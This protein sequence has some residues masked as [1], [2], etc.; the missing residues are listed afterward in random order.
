MAEGNLNKS[1]YIELKEFYDNNAGELYSFQ[2]FDEAGQTEYRVFTEKVKPLKVFEQN[3]IAYELV[4]I[5]FLSLKRKKSYSDI[6]KFIK[7][8]PVIY[9]YENLRGILRAVIEEDQDKKDML[10]N[11]VKDIIYNSNNEEM[12][13]LSIIAAQ[14]VK[15]ENLEEILEV[16][17]IHNKF[18]FYVINDYEHIDGSNEKIFKIAKSSKSYGKLFSLAALNMSNTYMEDWVIEKGCIDNYGITEITEYS[19]L[20]ADLLSY[21]NRTKFDYDKIEVFAKSFSIMISDYGISEIKDKIEVCQKLLEI[22]DDIGGGIYSLYAVVS[23]LYSVDGIIVDYYKEKQRIETLKN[24]EGYKNIIELCTDICSEKCWNDVIEEAIADIEIEPDVLVTCIE[25]TEYKLKKKE[26]ENLLKRDYLN[27]LLYKYALCV[28]NKAIRKSAF[29]LGVKNL[30]LNDMTTGAEELKI[31]ELTYDEISYICLYIII[32]YSQIKDFTDDISDCKELLLNS[33]QCPLIEIREECVNKLE[34]IKD[35]LNE[36]EVEFIYDCIERE[37]I[38]SIR[39]A[40]KCIA[41]ANDDDNNKKSIYVEPPER[42]QLHPKDTFLIDSEILGNDVFDRT[43]VESLI[44]ENNIVYV[45]ENPSED[46]EH[47]SVVSMNNGYIIGYIEKPVDDIL[48]NMI[49]SGRYIYG[50]IKNID[51]DLSEIKISIF[52]SYRDVEDGV[53]DVLSLLSKVKEEYVQ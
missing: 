35:I 36:G 11:F 15:L 29:K 50:K 21:F 32:K 18:I 31:D 3:R 40:L 14:V 51:E 13:K 28:G 25:K 5:L 2:D 30:P 53:S 1:Y 46:E 27:P 45:V 17:S 6:E 19:M 33:L 7:V 37:S 10:E 47:S 52:L 38:A 39:R 49:R 16:F 22:I 23:I 12:V 4:E 24:Y 26:Y 41:H 43:K 42:I 20:S 8:K 34:E 44:Q 48:G 9:Y